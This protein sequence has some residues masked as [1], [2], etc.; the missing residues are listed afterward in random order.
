MSSEEP[1]VTFI[2]PSKNEEKTIAEVIQKAQKAVQQLGLTYEIIVP[3]NSTDATPQIAR[4]LGAKVVTPDKHGYGYAYIYALRH[5][6]GKYIVM[7]DAD[8]TYD[9][10]E[11]PKLLEPLLKGEADIVLGTRLK[12]RILPGAMPWLHRYI[13]NPLLTFILNKF[14]GTNVSDAH[15]GFRAAKREAIQKLNLN[16]P[17]M[18]FASEFLAKAAYL[19]L[20]I[21]EV[22]ITYH[23][24]REGTQSKLNSLRDGWRHLKFLLILAPKFLYYIPGIAMLLMGIVLMLA[25]VLRAN[26]GY[27]P[28]IH[29][30]ILGSM[31]TILGANLAGL[32]LLAD[33]HLAKMIGR[34]SSRITKL[35]M[36][37]SVER[38]FML[39]AVL[40]VS[41]G[42][43]TL[44]LFTK[45]VE[46]G[47]RYLPLRG[48][49]AMALALIVLGVQVSASALLAH[50]VSESI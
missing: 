15:T 49:N 47:Y 6:R 34:P 1:D 2:F 29:S 20:R 28:G 32:G 37:M 11:A 18:E 12:G 14:Y 48:E 16:T 23:P 21:T 33:L 42:A 10:E 22:P 45:W 19:K 4:S 35:L 3:D 30:A 41:G 40:V 8:G 7:A 50:L 44:Y 17:G 31:L 9:L 27:S 38:A 46:S 26:L 13:G 24:R 36:K 5:A 43:Y 39:A 25:A